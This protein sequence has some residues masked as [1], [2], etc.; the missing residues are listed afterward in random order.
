MCHNLIRWLMVMVVVVVVG[1]VE[2]VRAVCSTV[3]QGPGFLPSCGSS[4]LYVFGFF[5]IESLDVETE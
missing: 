3:I 5:S 2:V 4:L 1:V